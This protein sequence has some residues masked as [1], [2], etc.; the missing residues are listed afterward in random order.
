M[1]EL[2]HVYEEPTYKASVTRIVSDGDG[3]I[4][5]HEVLKYPSLYCAIQSI[6]D[7][8]MCD[9]AIFDSIK[10]KPP[11]MCALVHNHECVDNGTSYVIKIFNPTMHRQIAVGLNDITEH[12]NKVF[13]FDGG[14]KVTQQGG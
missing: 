14:D 2:P 13:H 8:F 11:G 7:M 4:L 9:K 10:Y 3:N 5:E 1:A 12:A 6:R